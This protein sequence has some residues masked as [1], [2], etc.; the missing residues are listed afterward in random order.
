[1]LVQ[2]SKDQ[3]TE[4]YHSINGILNKAID[5]AKKEAGIDNPWIKGKLAASKWLG[6]S[7]NS[8]DK[9]MK[10][11]LPVHFI[12]DMDICFFNKQEITKYLLEK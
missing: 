9:L 5:D 11:G 7:R 10:Y 6:V 8:L 1:M 3:A 12:E 4:I 2:L